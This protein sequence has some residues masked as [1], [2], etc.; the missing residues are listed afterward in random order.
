MRCLIP[1]P[2]DIRP[3]RPSGIPAILFLALALSCVAAGSVRA[4]ADEKPLREP[5]YH[6][7]RPT[8]TGEFLAMCKE[9][10]LYCEEQFTSYIQRY[11]AV[12]VAEL[13]QQEEFRRMRENLRDPHAFD[14]ICLPRDKL[15]GE[16]L[17]VAMARAFRRWAEKHPELKG[18]RVPVG[19]KAAMQ[20]LYPCP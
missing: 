13:A 11:A 14:R 17:P 12:R 4:D 7:M 3:G 9:D 19:V 8:N 16:D 20:A 2:I 6:P 18:E 5:M 1:F 10:S 15:F